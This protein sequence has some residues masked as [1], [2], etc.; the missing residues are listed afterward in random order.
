M[1]RFG[2]LVTSYCAVAATLAPLALKPAPRLVWNASASVPVGL[3]SAR[4]G[5]P[6]RRGDLVAALAPEPIARLMAARGYLPLRVP[7]LKHVGAVG[8]QRVCR[9]GAQVSIDDI[10]V[11]EARERDRTGRPLPVWSGCR[12]LRPDEVFLV[13]PASPESFDGR[14]FGPVPARTIVAILT[15][16]WLPGGAGRQPEAAPPA[17][18]NSRPDSM[19]RNSR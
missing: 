15:P 13:N 5:D 17:R 6:A 11:A 8:G 1:K 7:M 18:A 16:F 3:Y 2:I 19:K 4:S 10:I 9:V 12:M 14:Y